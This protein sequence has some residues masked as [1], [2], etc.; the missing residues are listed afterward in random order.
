MLA[1]SEAPAK[2]RFITPRE[3]FYAMTR[4]DS[5]A[6][7]EGDRRLYMACAGARHSIV[8]EA[9]RTDDENLWDWV[10]EYR[11]YLL[12]PAGYLQRTQ[13]ESWRGVQV[14]FARFLKRKRRRS[15]TIENQADL[16]EELLRDK[17]RDVLQKERRF[18]EAPGLPS[19]FHLA[20]A[21]GAQSVLSSEEL[22]EKLPLLESRLDPVGNQSP[23]V[24]SRKDLIEQLERIFSLNGNAPSTPNILFGIV[25]PTLHPRPMMPQAADSEVLDSYAKPRQLLPD[26][27][28]DHIRF[29][30]KVD[31]LAYEF[32]ESLPMRAAQVAYHRLI[33]SQ[34]LEEIS[35]DIDA[36]RAT[37]HRDEKS[38]KDAFQM[39]IRGHELNESEIGI[40]EDV[41]VE[42]F[43]NGDYRPWEK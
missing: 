11:T 27:R 8:F 10:Y 1:A 23:E 31:I 43:R 28:I 42:M 26:E 24:V 39:L 25:W 14:S 41:I 38:F 37:V 36:S 9:K 18:R 13:L 2:K 34:T 6:V 20:Y 22:V 3:Y 19:H 32:L 17:L 40:L 4:G 15:K 21:P 30:E 29:I 33:L 16:Y 35:R 12:S 7:R 5:A